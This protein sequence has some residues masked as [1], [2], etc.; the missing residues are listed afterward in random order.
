MRRAKKWLG[1][2][3]ALAL[4]VAMG[5]NAFAAPSPAAGG[6]VK[7]E[8]VA[9]VD[10]N[11]NKI[12]VGINDNVNADVVADVKKADTLKAVLGD[13]YSSDMKVATVKDVKVD[14]KDL[15]ATITFAVSGVTAN[16]KVEVLHYDGTKWEKDTVSGVKAGN[17]TI[18]ATFSKLSPVAFVVGD[19]KGGNGGTTSP[20][21]GETSM[22]TV[23]VVA[24]VAVVAAVGLRKKEYVK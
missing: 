19:T 20:K 6:A 2:V 22:A 3:S 14:A 9:A 16:T 11:G 17:G 10:K 18:T 24:L 15:P 12:T 8:A 21:T 4:T 1:V 23:A 13:A 5:L 7:N